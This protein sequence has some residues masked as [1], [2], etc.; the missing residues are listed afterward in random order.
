MIVR[1]MPLHK[2]GLGRS[3]LR[4]AVSVLFLVGRATVGIDSAHRG[5]VEPS[6]TKDLRALST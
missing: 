1:F 4:G 6:D 5:R 2:K 3:G